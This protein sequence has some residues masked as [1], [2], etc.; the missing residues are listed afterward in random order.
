MNKIIITLTCFLLATSINSCKKECRDGY[1]KNSGIIVSDFNFGDCASSNEVYHNPENLEFF[2][3]N[4]ED[5]H[6][7]FFA[8]SC[9]NSSDTLYNKIDFSKFT[10]LGNDA[11]SDGGFDK[12]VAYFPN[13]NT[14]IYTIKGVKGCFG[15]KYYNKV[16]LVLINKIPDSTIV[17]FV[18]L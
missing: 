15:P 1:N 5:Y 17:K 6:N 7:L 12:N 10:L 9:I 8:T 16:H 11:G 18:V 2:I 4:N 3:N 14:C 13:E